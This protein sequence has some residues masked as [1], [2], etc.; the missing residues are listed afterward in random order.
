MNCVERST[1]C[2]VSYTHLIQGKLA[3]KQEK[4]Q[5]ADRQLSD[6]KANMDAIEEL[7]LIHI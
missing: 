2:S 5:T 6:L 1:V 3:D 7:S 4:L